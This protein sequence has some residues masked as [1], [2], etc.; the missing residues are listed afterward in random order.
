M[1]KNEDIFEKYKGLVVDIANKYKHLG[2]PIEDL[3]QE[4]MLGLLQA[5][6]KFKEEK[7]AK[8]STYAT[9][10]IKKYI[11]AAI[12]KEKK[13]SLNSIKL[14]DETVKDEKQQAKFDSDIKVSKFLKLTDDIPV[15]E[16]K[17]LRMLYEEQYTLKEIAEELN[18]SRER[19]RQLKEKALRRL[20]SKTK[21]QENS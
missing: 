20:R 3:I 11:L 18:I 4:G 16:Q 6:Q 17:V 14:V 10:W 21:N 7:G 1:K 12:E 19:T 2:L 5:Q 8:F 15:D 13:G 9:Y